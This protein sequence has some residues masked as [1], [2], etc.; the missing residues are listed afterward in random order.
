MT[1]NYTKSCRLSEESLEEMKRIF[2]EDQCDHHI[3]RIIHMVNSNIRSS[4]LR[5]KL[6][7]SRV[8]PECCSRDKMSLLVHEAFEAYTKVDYLMT[9]CYIRKADSLLTNT[10]CHHLLENENNG[11]CPMFY[12]AP[13]LLAQHMKIQLQISSL[14]INA[15]DL[16]QEIEKLHSIVVRLSHKEP[17]L[18]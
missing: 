12:L 9:T 5:S 4:E 1:E 18:Q 11:R 17:Y 15:T 2:A 6:I 14:L 8:S 10:E 7:R 13:S 16:Q 3:S